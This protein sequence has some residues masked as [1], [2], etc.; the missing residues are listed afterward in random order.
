MKNKILVFSISIFLSWGFQSCAPKPSKD[1][2]QKYLNSLL[3]NTDIEAAKKYCDSNSKE[4]I[5][6]AMLLYPVPDSVKEL[7]KSTKISI[8]DV[9]E[10]GDNAVVTYISSKHPENKQALKMVKI[11]GQWLVELNKV[12]DEKDAVTLAAT[13]APTEMTSDT[14]STTV[15]DTSSKAAEELPEKK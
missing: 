7:A 12:M 15:I 11:K 1:V 2:A 5:D 10:E 9:K 4:I 3:V 13:S 6:Q 8:V 14:T